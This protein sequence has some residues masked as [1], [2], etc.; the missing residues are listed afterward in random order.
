MKPELAVVMAV[1]KRVRRVGRESQGW[2]VRRVEFLRL[3]EVVA[4]MGVETGVGVLVEEAGRGDFRGRPRP[5]FIGGGSGAEVGVGN[6]AVAGEGGIIEAVGDWKVNVGKCIDC[7][8]LPFA[9]T[10]TGIVTGWGAEWAM[11]VS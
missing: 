6:G 11:R 1:V 2:G 3:G 7:G 5:F 9:G 8:G 10:D 4:G